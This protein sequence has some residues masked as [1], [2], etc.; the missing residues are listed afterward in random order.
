LRLLLDEHHDPE[1]A[2][3]LRERGH[4][5]AAVAERDDLRGR[6]DREIF[7]VAADEGRAAVTENAR[8]FVPLAARAADDDRPHHGLIVT[9]ASR[10]PRRPD[11][12]GR[13]ID[14]LARLLERHRG[15]DA[16]RDQVV[17]LDGE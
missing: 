9:A 14:A 3:R 13:L 6:P 15:D 5:V 17:W 7:D 16:L 10:S 4:D 8:D 11:S 2:R 12:R 1:V